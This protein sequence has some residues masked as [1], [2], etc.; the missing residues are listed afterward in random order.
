MP[1]PTSQEIKALGSQLFAEIESGGKDFLAQNTA[2]KDLLIDRTEEL[3]KLTLQYKFE[4]DADAKADL[5]N[6]MKIVQQTIQNELSALALAGQA[7][8]KD[9]FMKVVNTAVA[10]LIKFVPMLL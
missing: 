3:A 5:L 8:A 6:E 2:A 4:G 10:A 9:L 7:A 1:L